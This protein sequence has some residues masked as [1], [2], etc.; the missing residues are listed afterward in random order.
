MAV[1][2]ARLLGPVNLSSGE[3][4][5]LKDLISEVA[6]RCGSADLLHFGARPR[7]PGDPDTIVGDNTRLLT[8]V[9]WRPSVPRGQMLDDIVEYWRSLLEQR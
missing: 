2:G 4:V 1:S 9:P 5:R 7:R 8:E 3:G 6:S